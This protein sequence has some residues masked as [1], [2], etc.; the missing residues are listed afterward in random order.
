MSS[1]AIEDHTPRYVVIGAGAVGG[2]IA[3]HLREHDN[4]VLLVARG[5]HGNRISADG[6]KVR[7]P[8]GVDVVRLPIVAGA[9][10]SRLLRGDVLVLAVKTQDAESAI[11]EWAW[12]PVYDDSGEVVGS[13]SELLPILTTQNGL[14]TEDLALRRFARVYG[15]TVGVNAS[16]LSPGEIVSPSVNPAAHFWIG[17][18]PRPVSGSDEPADTLLERIVADFNSAGLAAWSVDDV[19]ATKGAKLLG[20]LQFNGVDVLEGSD[21]DRAEARALIR[22]EAF[23][24]LEK[25]GWPLPPGG[26]LDNHGVAFEVQPVEG[27]TNG[28]SSTWNSFARGGSNE[29]DFL[30]GEIVLQARKLGIRAPL[31]ER[32][33]EVLNAPQFEGRRTIEAVLSRGREDAGAR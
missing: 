14:A 23:D 10:D 32:V 1:L 5:E 12:Q 27:H 31:N 6:L 13:A 19:R 29:V 17:R 15:V 11:A 21:A 9:D 16:Y 8:T 3:A 7:R 30:H 33:Q 26:Q 24:I 25:A 2:V 20:N 28:R 4:N 22:D 18:Y